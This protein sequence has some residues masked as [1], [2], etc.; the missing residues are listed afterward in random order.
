MGLT[1]PAAA[2]ATVPDE[3]LLARLRVHTHYLTRGCF[4]PEAGVLAGASLAEIPATLV[5][6]RLDFVCPPENA[7]TLARAL[8]RARLRLLD[9]AGHSQMEPAMARALVEELARFASELQQA[10][11]RDARTPGNR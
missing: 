8:P 1:D 3:A 2:D 4:L 10:G 9:G 7:V 5:H 6:G 11:R